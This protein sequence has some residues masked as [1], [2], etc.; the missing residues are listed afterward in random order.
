MGL[1][2]Y[3]FKFMIFWIIPFS[4][5]SFSIIGIS[6]FALSIYI[7]IMKFYERAKTLFRNARDKLNNPTAKRIIKKVASYGV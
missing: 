2:F 7:I 3:G 1:I 4:I 6:S 5:L